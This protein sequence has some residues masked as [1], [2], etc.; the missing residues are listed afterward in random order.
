MNQQRWYTGQGENMGFRELRIGLRPRSVSAA[1][2]VRRFVWCVLS[3]LQVSFNLPPYSCE[4]RRTNLRWIQEHLS[5]LSEAACRE[6]LVER[7]V[8]QKLWCQQADDKPTSLPKVH[9]SR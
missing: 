6:V 8:E 2:S 7:C 4:P 1:I 5:I 9:H 3:H